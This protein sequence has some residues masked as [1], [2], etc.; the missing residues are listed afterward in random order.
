MAHP[1]DAGTTEK[2]AAEVLIKGRLYDVTGFHHPGG[3]II[4]FLTG[5]GDATEAYGEFHARSKMAEKV[6]A[7]L[8]NREAPAE[9]LA[10]RAG[11]GKPG[12][13]KD[14]QELR[15]QLVAEGF[16]EPSMSECLYRVTEIAVMK[17]I[18]AYMFMFCAQ[19]GIRLLG[20]L[21]IGIA[22][23]RCGWLMHEAGHHSMTGHIPTDRV[24]QI[25]LYGV[26]CG[27]SGAWWRNQHN[28]HHATPQKLQH[29]VDLDTLPLVAFNASVLGRTSSPILKAWLRMQGVLFIPVSCLL[30]TL[31]WSLYLHPRY[32]YRVLTTSRKQARGAKGRA[33]GEAVSLI[34]R[35]LLWFGVLTSGLSWGHALT[36][37]LVH[38]AVAGMYIFTNFS[39]SHTHL[40]VTKPDQY[41]HWVEYAA[42]HTTNIAPGPVCDWW[43]A[44]LNY[45]IEHHLFPS[46]PQ[47]RHPSVSPRVRVL[48]A[49]H[50]LP[51]DTRPYFGCLWETL[52][53]LHE[54]G[55]VAQ[56]RA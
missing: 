3:N 37:Y 43:M 27:M 33:A 11:N 44:Y 21:I 54:V 1:A 31:F 50:G 28:K 51:Y 36:C 26:G 53:N 14:Y 47:F 2:D 5:G 52:A 39:L 22:T 56:K 25:V 16:F 49:K 20:L 23:G 38:F 35:Y 6:L 41:L 17:L 19:P 45:Q 32:I 8:P 9:V 42:L 30:V 10:R 7:S 4:S 12:I 15:D 34:V 13:S 18:G 46:M 55:R 29:D 40:P 48:F 24:L